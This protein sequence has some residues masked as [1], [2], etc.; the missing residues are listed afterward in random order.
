MIM[1]RRALAA[2]LAVAVGLS[3]TP[4]LAGDRGI[5]VGGA[6]ALG[7][8]GGLAVGGAVAASNNAYYPGRPVY[9]APP[10]PPDYVAAPAY[11]PPPPRR[12][13]VESDCYVQ[14]RRYV[15]E[16]GDVVIRKVR[17]CE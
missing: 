13:Y 3:A 14:R 9:V 5:G 11:A 15:D 6:V 12:V 2:G 16:F 7:A 1:K 4:T 17:V 8:L 10:P